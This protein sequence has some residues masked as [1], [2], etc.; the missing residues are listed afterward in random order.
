MENGSNDYMNIKQLENLKYPRQG[1]SLC[2]LGLNSLVVTGSRCD[3]DGA[4][5]RAEMYKIKENTWTTL[6]DLNIARH[7]HS[8]TS[9]KDKAIYIFCGINNLT[10]KYL[11][12]IEKYEFKNP[13]G[14][15][16]IEP[17]VRMPVRQGCGVS[18]INTNE[19]LIFGGYS[20]RM[21]KDAYTLNTD[22]E[23]ILPLKRQPII[24]IF[25]YQM[26]TIF[27][28]KDQTVYTVDWSKRKIYSLIPN[29]TDWRMM[30]ELTIFL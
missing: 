14:W 22:T 27:D 19:I 23:Q 20:A 1:H 24:E 8:S 16:L 5:K 3:L 18:V 2:A 15:A 25:A 29:Q 11:N 4:G 10:K 17:G 21:L 7:Y 9:F 28:P 30:Q 13:T 26:P 6:P 12:S